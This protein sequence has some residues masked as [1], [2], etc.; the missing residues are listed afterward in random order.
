MSLLLLVSLCLFGGLSLLFVL[1]KTDLGHFD[2][3]YR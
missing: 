1:L 2:S 3:P